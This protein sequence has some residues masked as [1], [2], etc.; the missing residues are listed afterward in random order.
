V[1]PEASVHHATV[2][3]VGD[4]LQAD[5]AGAERVGIPVVLVRKADSRV[6]QWCPTLAA[7][8]ALLR[9]AQ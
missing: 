4:D 2:W 1:V 9:K 5:I 8:E 3:I 7:L 6:R